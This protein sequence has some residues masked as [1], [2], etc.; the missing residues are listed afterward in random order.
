MSDSPHLQVVVSILHRVAFT[1]AVP[2]AHSLLVIH[3]INLS[4]DIRD[5]EECRQRQ[6]RVLSFALTRP[7]PPSAGLEWSSDEED[8][9]RVV[10]GIGSAD[11]ADSEEQ[12]AVEDCLLVRHLQQLLLEFS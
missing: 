2:C 6:E 10:G 7:L 3:R 9:C 12:S 4:V 8:D 5:V 1:S 11:G